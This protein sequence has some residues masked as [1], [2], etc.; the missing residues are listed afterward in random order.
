VLHNISVFKYL[1]IPSKIHIY[2]CYA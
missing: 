1:L 2:V